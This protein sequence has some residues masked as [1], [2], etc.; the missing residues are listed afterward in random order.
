MNN[1]SLLNSIKDKKAKAKKTKAPKENSCEKLVQKYAQEKKCIITAK[2]YGKKL[3]YDFQLLQ[4]VKNGA[5]NGVLSELYGDKLQEKIEAQKRYNAQSTE[6]KR[7]NQSGKSTLLPD[8][9]QDLEYLQEH[10]QEWQENNVYIALDI[11]EKQKQKL[12]Q[13][14]EDIAQKE[15]AKNGAKAPKAKAK[16]S[17]K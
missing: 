11:I 8:F 15:N 2:I 6:E 14:L 16:T 5:K 10:A 4:N 9:M 7:K 13:K 17:A 3:H 1:Q 12:A